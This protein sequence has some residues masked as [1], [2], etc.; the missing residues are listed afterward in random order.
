MWTSESRGGGGSAAVVWA[1]AANP[2]LSVFDLIEC[3]GM[4]RNAIDSAIRTC[5]KR[6][7]ILYDLQ[8]RDLGRGGRRLVKC[9]AL[10]NC[11][12]T[13][14]VRRYCGKLT[15]EAILELLAEQPDMSAVEIAQE[16]GISR[17]CVLSSLGRLVKSGRVSYEID[18][19]AIRCHGKRQ[20]VVMSKVRIFSLARQKR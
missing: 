18:E 4:S 10:T 6:D 11:R 2:W 7:L 8:P 17:R 20:C 16:L 5:I 12:F 3:L 13:A 14:D 19:R 9:Y 1:L 15:H